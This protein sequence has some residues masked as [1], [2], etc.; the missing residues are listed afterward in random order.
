[1]NTINTRRLVLLMFV[2]FLMWA[3]IAAFAAL[4][5]HISYQGYLTATDGTPI[6]KNVTLQLSLYDVATGGT[7]LWTEQQVAAVTTG[8]FS[9]NLGSAAPF[10]LA[11]DKPYYL[12]IKVDADQEMAPRQAFTSSPYALRAGVANSVAD[13]SITTASLQDASVTAGKLG[14]SCTS[15]QVL[16][17]TVSGWGCGTV[18]SSGGTGTVTGIIAGNGVTVSG[19]AAV[20]QIDISFGGNGTAV[21]ASRS[22]HDHDAMYQKK[23]GKVAVVAK[24]GSDYLT[25]AT[26]L[27]DVVTWCGVPSVDNPC[28]VKVMPGIYSVGSNPVNMIDFVDIE[29][30]GATNTIISGSIDSAIIGVV[31]TAN[32]TLKNI[33]VRNIGGSNAQNAIAIAATYIN[34]IGS[35]VV[36]RSSGAINNYRIF[37]D[38][39]TANAVKDSTPPVVSMTS[40]ADKVVMGDVSK[41]ITVSF[42]EQIDDLAIADANITVFDSTNKAVAGKIRTNVQVLSNGYNSFPPD[43]SLVFTP[44]LP[45]ARNTAYNVTVSGVKDLAGNVM[46]APY[47]FSFTTAA[48]A[49][50]GGVTAADGTTDAKISWQ[51]VSGATSYNLYWSASPFSN[52]GGSSPAPV[53]PYGAPVI[54]AAPVKIANITSPYSFTPTSAPFSGTLYATLTGA[55]QSGSNFG[56]IQFDVNVPVGV[57][58]TNVSTYQFSSSQYLIPFNQVSPGV[59]RIAL[60]GSPYTYFPS[61]GSFAI[62]CSG[63]FTG[64]TVPNFTV[65]NLQVVD[66]N[67][68]SLTGFTL[69]LANSASNGTAGTPYYFA[70]TATN[71]SGESVKSNLASATIDNKPPVVLSALMGYS[72]DP[73]TGQPLSALTVNSFE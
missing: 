42:S 14:I 11:F 34:A 1:M 66:T 37:T 9:I 32:A 19:T 15:G 47:T 28:L 54:P 70:V 51:P 50:P 35:D 52:D 49:A 53:Y 24:S 43:M 59:V 4:P 72:Y 55:L 63:D 5:Q 73:L 60:I 62:N 13:G 8:Q 39:A 48:V 33:A 56:A 46:P 45:L 57:T 2:L 3:P 21:T 64:V 29:G 31:N 7:P 25:P 20:P 17:H 68:A 10:N 67:G 65:S 30:S 40:P 38:G 58:V 61:G 12:G 44:A 71:T 36:A 6:N 22:D 23:Y 41:G 26:A 16:M 18:S 69:D 27:A